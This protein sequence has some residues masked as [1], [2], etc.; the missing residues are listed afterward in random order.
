MN[1]C[2]VISSGNCRKNYNYWRVV[3]FLGWLVYCRALVIKKS[4][5]GLR[6]GY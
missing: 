6:T 4:L 2:G 3:F 1:I 5:E